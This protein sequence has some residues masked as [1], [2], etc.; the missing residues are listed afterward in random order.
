MGSTNFPPRFGSPQQNPRV[1]RFR[2]LHNQQIQRG[3]GGSPL[4]AYK[5]KSAKEEDENNPDEEKSTQEGEKD[6]DNKN[7]DEN[8]VPEDGRKET[9]YAGV[10]LEQKLSDV[11]LNGDK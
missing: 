2:A 6:E 7:E 10:D 9:G 3:K 4:K 11:N 1:R 5:K 8:G